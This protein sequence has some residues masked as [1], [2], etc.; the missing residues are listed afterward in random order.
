MWCLGCR[1]I[2]DGCIDTAPCFPI[3]CSGGGDGGGGDDMS[4]KYISKRYFLQYRHLFRIHLDK[5]IIISWLSAFD[6][7]PR[8]I[9]VNRAPAHTHNNDMHAWNT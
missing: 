8:W 2:L 9:T 6:R 4:Y 3:G 7:A 5:W 1:R